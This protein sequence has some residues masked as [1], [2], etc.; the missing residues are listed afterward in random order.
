VTSDRR[1][2]SAGFWITVTLVVVLVAY[3][4]SYGPVVW[5]ESQPRI[6]DSVPGWILDSVITVYSPLYFA[7]QDGPAII[8]T[9]LRWYLRLWV[10]LTDHDFEP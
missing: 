3:P 2:P 7:A 8:R 9:P 1:K 10:G 5:C 6:M 4:L